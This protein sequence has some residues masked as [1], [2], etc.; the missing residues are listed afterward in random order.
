[1]ILKFQRVL[2]SLNFNGVVFRPTS[3]LGDAAEFIARSARNRC[4]I[5]IQK[6]MIKT[7][8]EQRTFSRNQSQIVNKKM[9]T[10]SSAAV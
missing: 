6:L 1:M 8:D 4:R 2:S 7:T 5:K 3:A 9:S 10:Y